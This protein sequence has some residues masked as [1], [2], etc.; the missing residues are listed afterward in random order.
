M[1]RV[2][3]GVTVFHHDLVDLPAFEPYYGRTVAS[4]TDVNLLFDTPR[5]LDH[6]DGLRPEEVEAAVAVFLATGDVHSHGVVY[7]HLDPAVDRFRGLDATQQAEFKDALDKFVR[8]YSFLESGRQ[9][10]RHQSR[11]LH[12]LPRPGDLSARRVDQRPPRPPHRGRA[13]PPSH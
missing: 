2:D 4:P 6:C 8:R 12:L 11:G 9:L 13:V 1:A 7:A 5:Q 10:R 3:Q